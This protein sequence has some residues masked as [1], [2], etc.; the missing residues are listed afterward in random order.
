MGERQAVL[1]LEPELPIDLVEQGVEEA[2]GGGAPLDHHVVPRLEERHHLHARLALDGRV[3][4]VRR[5]AAGH[6]H[7]LER[8]QAR[9][10]EQAAVAVL[11]QARQ[12]L[13][14]R[15]VHVQQLA[16][17]RH[18]RVG[19][20]LRQLVEGHDG[21]PRPVRLRVRRHARARPRVA[22]RH[23]AD[24]R[25]RRRPD[26]RQALHEDLPERGD[27]D[28]G[29]G[30]GER[31]VVR[32]EEVCKG[33]AHC[34]VEG[35]PIRLTEHVARAAVEP[36]VLPVAQ[37]LAEPLEEPGPA[38][39]PRQRVARRHLEA[40]GQ[41][42]DA[43]LPERGAV[44]LVRLLRVGAEHAGLEH[45]EARDGQPFAAPVRAARL[46]GLVG[47]LG[48]GAGVE[49]H[50]EEEEVEEAAGALL[51]V[52]A[53]G[54]QRQQLVDAGAAADLEVLPA[55]VGGD[56][57]VVGRVVA[58]DD[59]D[60]VGRRL[61]ELGHVDVEVGQLV[62][63]RALVDEA[64]ALAHREQAAQV[65]GR[66]HVGV[67]RSRQGHAGQR[68]RAEAGAGAG[69]LDAARRLH[70]RAAVGRVAVG[71]HLG[72]ALATEET[73]AACLPG[74]GSGRGGDPGRVATR[75]EDGRG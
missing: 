33:S 60:H 56:G 28:D 25:P 44:D 18:E 43:D 59:A 6:V 37:R 49:Q 50:G 34:A 8:H 72:G 24:A 42:L 64:G 63:P 3:V 14:P 29:D 36:K 51:V 1:L 55:A 10:D 22:Q 39:Q 65:R 31:R 45:L 9:V 4:L 2:D 54:P 17:G 68:Q 47:P 74:E 11:G 61:D 13:R 35:I 70:R 52:D 71:R 57:V 75:L 67:G 23:A 26:G 19:Q 32:H 27:G 38:V 21:L 53:Q 58:P 40:L 41:L 66:V 30:G 73:H 46:L 20:P 69:R 7:L 62:A 48:A 5:E 15:E 12:Q 16:H